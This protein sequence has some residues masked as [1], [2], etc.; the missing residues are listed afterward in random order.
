MADKHA[1]YYREFADKVIDQIKRGTAPWQKP[2]EPGERSL[3]E[4]VSTGNRYRGGN[5]VYL[6]AAAQEKG[7]RD[8]RWGT[9]RQIKAMGGQVRK[10]ERGSRILSFQDRRRIALKDEHGKPKK[11]KDGKQ[12]YRFEKLKRPYI[13]QYTVFNAEQARGLPAP[14]KPEAEPAWMPQQRAEAVIRAAG[15]DVRHVQGDRAYYH[16]KR[17][18]VVLPERSQFPSAKNYYQTALHEVA[19]STGHPDRMNRE[20]LTKGVAGGFGSTEYAREELRAE[21][22]AMMTSDRLKTG[23]DP[24]RGAAYVEGWIQALE[25]DP[26]EIHRASADAQKISTRLIDGAREILQQIDKEHTDA[27]SRPEDDR[28]LDRPAERS[29]E[30]QQDRAASQEFSR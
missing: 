24:E 9:Y 15:V 20:T 29:A 30:R 16:L 11:D 8:H 22:S 5:T 12:I 4:N 27:R 7:Y 1:E 3:P 19:H 26:R 17:D 6:A 14:P 28:A 10:G 25:E 18:E 23:H 2:W 21:I 13:R